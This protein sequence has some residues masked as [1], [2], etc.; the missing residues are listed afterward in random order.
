MN[1]QPAAHPVGSR[2][3]VLSSYGKQRGKIGF[4][5]GCRTEDRGRAGDARTVNVYL[6][7]E[8]DSNT[9]VGSLVGGCRTQRPHGHRGSKVI[10]GALISPC[11]IYRYWLQRLW[12]ET[13][14]PC[15]F[16]M[17]NPSTADATVDDATIKRVVGFSRTWGFGGVNVY[18]LFALRA[19]DPN[20]LLKHPDPVGPDNDAYLAQIPRTAVIIAAWGNGG[21]FKRRDLAVR[22]MFLGRLSRLGATNKGQ[23]PH[24]LYQPGTKMYEPFPDPVEFERA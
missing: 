4:I 24:P 2:V 12:D 22:R 15:A 11:G 21:S 1:D 3:V 19:T 17:L 9:S 13:R 5:R 7:T 23:P 8:T 10:R 16:I 18:N 6:V 14:P 20:E